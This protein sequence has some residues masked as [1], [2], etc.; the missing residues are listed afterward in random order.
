[1]IILIFTAFDRVL[2]ICRKKILC[3]NSKKNKLLF[4]LE[5]VF[6][7]PDFFAFFLQV[8]YFKP[9]WCWWLLNWVLSDLDLIFFSPF[10]SFCMFWIRMMRRL[11]RLD[12]W[13]IGKVWKNNSKKRIFKEWKDFFLEKALSK[14]SLLSTRMFLTTL[15]SMLSRLGSWNMS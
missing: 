2:R 4:F 10:L 3:G 12:L 9:F 14:V 5:F 7:W 13:K 6:C 11:F 15:M 1:L 8:A